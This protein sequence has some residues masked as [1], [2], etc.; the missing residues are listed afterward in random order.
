VRTQVGLLQVL[1]WC[2]W[3]L[4]P[5]RNPMWAHLLGHKVLRVVTPALLAVAGLAALAAA[6]RLAGAGW[7]LAAA[8]ALAV[9][10]GLAFAVR[11][12]AVRAA[13]D[14]LAWLVRLQAAP[15]IAVARAARGDWDVW[16]P[17]RA[18]AATAPRR[19]DALPNEA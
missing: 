1:A 2:P 12:A 14:R 17:A 19:G 15:L 3:V 5:A 9:A 8:A 10:G 13:A 7:L 16:R 11:P 6:A 4:N 18:A